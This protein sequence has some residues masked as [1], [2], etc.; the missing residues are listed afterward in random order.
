MGATKEMYGDLI[1]RVD[2]SYHVYKD[3]QDTWEYEEHMSL[4]KLH[5]PQHKEFFKK[6]KEWKDNTDTLKEVMHD[7]QDIEWRVRHENDLI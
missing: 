5:N 6:D 7:R 2:M 3:L 4:L 1:A